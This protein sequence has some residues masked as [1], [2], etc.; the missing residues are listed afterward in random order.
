MNF[1]TEAEEQVML[2]LWKLNKATTKEIVSEYN[3]PKPA[4]NTISTII[5]ILENKKFIKHKKDGKKY[6]Y[7]SKISKKEYCDALLSR[8]ANDFYD[9]D[10]A[11]FTSATI[12]N[13]SLDNITQ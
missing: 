7:H 6:I 2:K 10:Y 9:G 12:S 5:R 11:A 3:E 4:Y 13:R 1:L 8:L